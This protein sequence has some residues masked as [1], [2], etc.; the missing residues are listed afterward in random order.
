MGV[1]EAPTMTMGSLLDMIVPRWFFPYAIPDGK[2][3]STFPGMALFCCHAKCTI[4]ADDFTVEHLVF[5]DMAGKSRIFFRTP[6]PRREGHG[7]TEGILHFL[8]HAGHHR[9]GE[10]S[11][12]DGHDPDAVTRKFAGDR[13]SHRSNAALGSGIG[14][15]TDLAV[16]GCNRCGVDD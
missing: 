10:N 15:L 3:V 12:C 8:R 6:Q 2:P 4:Q 11:R 9:R 16:K 13:Q 1:R 5:H 14:S 7:C